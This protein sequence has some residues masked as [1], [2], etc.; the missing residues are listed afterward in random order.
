MRETNRHADIQTNRDRQRG[1]EV[2]GERDRDRYIDIDIE[3]DRERK[4][5]QCQTGRQRFTTRKV[6]ET[7]RQM[8]TERQTNS[9]DSQRQREATKRA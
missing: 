4:Q 6:G 1:G 9:L 3:A 5:R 8:E 2:G 7:R